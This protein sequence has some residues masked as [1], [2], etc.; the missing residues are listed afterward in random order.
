M[1]LMN[2]AFDREIVRT[3]GSRTVY[4]SERTCC[5]CASES[6]CWETPFIARPPARWALRTGWIEESVVPYMKTIYG[7]ICQA[8]IHS[9]PQMAERAAV[10]ALRTAV[11]QRGGQQIVPEWEQ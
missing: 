11:S 5:N 4:R 8:F 6:V 10:A 7:G 2:T 3:I 9:D 1:T